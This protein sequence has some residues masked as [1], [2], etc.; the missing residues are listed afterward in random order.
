MVLRARVRKWNSVARISCSPLRPGCALT[1]SQQHCLSSGSWVFGLHTVCW[2]LTCDR[3][4][5]SLSHFCQQLWI[6]FA[7]ASNAVGWIHAL[8]P[9][10]QVS[11]TIVLLKWLLSRLPPNESVGQILSF[12]CPNLQLHSLDKLFWIFMFLDICE[13]YHSQFEAYNTLD[14]ALAFLSVISFSICGF[15][16]QLK[17]KNN[18]F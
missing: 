4:L 6:C 10:S 15:S 8:K 16:T 17:G 2:S 12:L 5:L 1:W 7:F 13:V 3:T 9:H 11:L 18:F 14:Q